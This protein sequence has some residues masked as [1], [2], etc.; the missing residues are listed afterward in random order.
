[1]LLRGAEQVVEE[2]HVQLQDFDELDPAAVDDV[3]FAVKVPR[4][5]DVSC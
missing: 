5:G 2:R 4:R 1:V 3:Q